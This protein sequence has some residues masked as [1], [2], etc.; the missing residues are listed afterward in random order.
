MVG[1]GGAGAEKK[2]KTV[3][4]SCLWHSGKA[5]SDL[6]QGDGR[7]ASSVHQQS[8][9]ECVRAGAHHSRA[10]L[11]AFSKKQKEASGLTVIMWLRPLCVSSETPVHAAL[12]TSRKI[13]EPRSESL[14]ITARGPHRHTMLCFCSSRPSSSSLSQLPS[15]DIDFFGR[16]ELRGPACVHE[17]A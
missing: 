13:P 14:S 1:A 2:K 6:P 15:V 5:A 3:P 16:N 17:C 7:R 9:G 4:T 12:R 11:F 10:H 8:A